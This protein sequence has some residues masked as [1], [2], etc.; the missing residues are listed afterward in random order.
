MIWSPLVVIGDFN[1][2]R[3]VIVLF[4]AD[5]VLIV[6]PDAELPVAVAFQRFES[7]ARQYGE[8]PERLGGVEHPKFLK[9]L[10]LTLLETLAASSQV[11][12]SGLLISEV[13][14]QYLV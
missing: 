2:V 1:I 3:V 14:N 6:D 11:Q 10:S 4:E 13:A 7:I 9:S 8:V 12:M 5:P